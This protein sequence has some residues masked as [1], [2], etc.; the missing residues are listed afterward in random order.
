[1]S[2]TYTVIG[3]NI[4]HDTDMG[5]E[6]AERGI[7]YT[8]TELGTCGAHTISRYE[9]TRRGEARVIYE[10]AA[11]YD[12]DAYSAESLVVDRRIGETR[13]DLVLKAIHKHTRPRLAA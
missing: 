3:H 1:M 2:K 11:M 13:L 4:L 12:A 10:A 7:G 5:A 9:Y 8:R 6:F